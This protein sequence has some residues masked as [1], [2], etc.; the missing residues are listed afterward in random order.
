MPSSSWSVKEVLHLKKF[1]PRPLLIDTSPTA[2]QI[3]FDTNCIE[4]VEKFLQDVEHKDR[5][6]AIADR[7][8]IHTLTSEFSKTLSE[9]LLPKP[10]IDNPEKSTPFI[11][12]PWV[13][14]KKTL[15]LAKKL[16]STNLKQW[17]AYLTHWIRFEISEICEHL[18]HGYI[19]GDNLFGETQTRIRLGRI[20][21][22]EEELS[23][24]V[25]YS[26]QIISKSFARRWTKK[27]SNEMIIRIHLLF[28]YS[29]STF[30]LTEIAIYA[31]RI[32]CLL[33]ENLQLK[34]SISLPSK[35]GVAL[36]LDSLRLSY[37]QPW[38]N[39]FIT[40]EVYKDEIISRRDKMTKVIINGTTISLYLVHPLITVITDYSWPIHLLEL[41][42]THNTNMISKTNIVEL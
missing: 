19:C 34:W 10:K 11:D 31:G 5:I 22:C 20:Q 15:A 13:S 28:G 40:T 21:I 41:I 14:T 38:M 37:Y 30:D 42:S 8:D 7:P 29:N 35:S 4:S 9:F 12:L 25:T 32:A 2:L 18:E 16:Y 17:I 36:I 33:I 1:Y 39:I 27:S 3:L 24:Y 26:Q 23:T 6:N